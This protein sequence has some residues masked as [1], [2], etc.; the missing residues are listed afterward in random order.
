M[1]GDPFADELP[2]LDAARV[3][4]RHPRAGDDVRVLAIFGDPVAMRYWSHEPLADLEVAR[5]YLRAI[6]RGFAERTLFQWAIADREDDELIGTVTL[7][8]WSARHGRAELGY[9]LGPAFW[10]RG[11]ATEAVRAVIDFGF[12]RMELHRIE[13]DVDPRNRA[14]VAL[15]ERLGFVR[16]GFLRERWLTYGERSD[17]ALY[18][19]LRSS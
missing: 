16:E 4:L 14:S 11:F 6:D 18:G 8:N 1:L 2:V 5:E 13:A 10:N 17:S 19:L 12:E 15:L 9:M 7:Y 3:R